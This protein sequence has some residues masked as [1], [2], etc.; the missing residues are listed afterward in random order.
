[1]I[2]TNSQNIR[3]H[4][5]L[6]E[7]GFGSRR[8][9][10]KL[11]SIKKIF[12]NNKIAILGQKVSIGDKI[13]IQQS[14]LVVDDLSKTHHQHLIYNKP[15]GEICSKNDP[16]GRKT[17]FSALPKLDNQRWISIGRLDINTSGL[18]LFTTDGTIANNWMHPSNG[19]EREYMVRTFGI[20]TTNIRKSML[21]GIRLN[22]GIA[23][24]KDIS[25]IKDSN[26]KWFKVT[27]EEGRNRF[28]RRMFEYHKIKVSR[29][30]RIRYGD[31]S[32][33]K[34]LKKGRYK[35]VSGF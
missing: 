11:I 12:V 22:D 1:M 10:E 31:I 18:L 25:Q 28:I 2:K 32:L 19:Y 21:D 24:F 16:G 15:E 8:S 20:F 34:D 26:N 7:K 17:T 27:V 14:T 33:P 6:S 23:K 4:K 30:I 35:I 29:L 13:K 5:Y 9:I 3:L